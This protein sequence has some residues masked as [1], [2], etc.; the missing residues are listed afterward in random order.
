MK[1]FPVSEAKITRAIVNEFSSWFQEYVT[2]DVIIAGGGPSGLMA[3][4]DLA[5]KGV[6]TL[7]IESNNFPGGGFWV[8]GYFMNTLT[9]R[10]P[11]EEIL[12]ELSI[13]HKRVEDGLFVSDGPLTC[14][15]LIAAACEAGAKILNMTRFEDVIYREGRVNGVVINWSAVS[16]LPRAMAALDPVSLESEVVV[17]ATG[18]DAYVCRSLEKRGLLEMGICGP[19]DVIS[20][21]DGVVEKTGEVLPGLLV[22]GMSVSTL[23][24]IPRMGPTFG[25][26][27]F[28]GR[29]AALE[30]MKL[31]EKQKDPSLSSEDVQV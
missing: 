20:S 8:G 21:E 25:S 15:K 28:S 6:K 4:Y 14:S 10:S 29:K 24:G 26:M 12:S 19:M 27:L 11:S 17:D 7:V 3:A 30:A 2:S 31:L 16:A 23:F 18:H 1:F 22:C 5:K 9:F 13:V